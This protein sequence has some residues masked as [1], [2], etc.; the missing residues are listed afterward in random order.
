MAADWREREARLCAAASELGAATNAL[1][2]AVE[3]D[4]TPRRFHERDIRVI[5]AGRFVDSLIQAIT[6]PIIRSFVDGL[7]VRAGVGRLPGAI[8]QAVDST[9]VLTNPAR[10]RA[11]AGLLGL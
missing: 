5:D 2:L 3:V 10:C 8:D 4:P 1:R 7:G 11:A 9:D 6:D